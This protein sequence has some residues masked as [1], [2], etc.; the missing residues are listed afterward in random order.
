MAQVTARPLT[1]YDYWVLPES[2][3]RY[4]LI[5]GNLF[6]A[7]A[8]N[9]FHQD[10]SRTIQF[11]MMKYLEVQPVG[12]VYDAPFDVVL[13]DINVFQPDLAFFSERRRRFL[14]EKGAEGS[15]DLVVE[16][17]SPKTAHLDLDQ[18]RVVYSR[19]G[20]DELWIVDPAGEEVRVYHLRE[21]PNLPKVILSSGDVLKTSLLPGFEIS[22]KKIFQRF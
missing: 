14:T 9:R 1:K 8:P 15:P 17:L 4:Q 3:P 16:I 10:I 12:I 22:V 21:D 13:S 20:V 2:G 7:P 18:K 11:E 6:M 19:A 5:N